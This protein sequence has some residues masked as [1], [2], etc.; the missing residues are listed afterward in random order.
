MNVKNTKRVAIITGASRGIGACCARQFANTGYRVSLVARSEQPLNELVSELEG[1]GGESLAIAGDLGDLSFCKEVVSRT[2]GHFGRVDALVN[3]AAWREPISMRRLSPESWEKTIRVCLTAPAFLSRWVA[4]DMELRRSGVI[5]N[6]SSIQSQQ[7]TGM[8]SAYVACKGGLD[9][10]TYD[11]ASLYGAVGIR[12]VGIRPGA[13]DTEMSADL[14]DQEGGTDAI[15]EHS[16]DMIAMQRWAKPEEIAKVIAF[17][18]S[19]D[20]SYITGTNL[21]VDGG[22]QHQQLPLSFRREQFPEDYR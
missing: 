9:S 15:L 18:A 11:L 13:I 1:N 10:L 21:L 20:A 19:D 3:N 12:V 5:I 4:E 14:T 17:L 6:V 22:W 8:G 16:N 2:V 7:T